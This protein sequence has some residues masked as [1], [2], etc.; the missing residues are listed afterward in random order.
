MKLE[1]GD[2]EASLA[3]QMLSCSAL[4][5][6]NEGRHTRSFPFPP[7][8]RRAVRPAMSFPSRVRR[9][10]QNEQ[11]GI[12]SL[13]KPKYLIISHQRRRRLI[14]RRSLE[15]AAEDGSGR[16]KMKEDCCA[17][18]VSGAARQSI[19]AA[20]SP[21]VRPERLNLKRLIKS[22]CVSRSCQMRNSES[23]GRE[24]TPPRY[25]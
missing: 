7:R 21:G 17:P 6:P 12:L 14:S 22:S 4:L 25:L 16:R 24:K 10:R 20:I 18:C 23:V 11:I 2:N 8:S 9:R 5:G 15:E 13:S 19:A 3:C 1:M